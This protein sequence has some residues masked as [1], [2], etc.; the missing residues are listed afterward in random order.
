MKYKKTIGLLAALLVLAFLSVAIVPTIYHGHLTL[1]AVLWGLSSLAVLFGVTAVNYKYPTNVAPTAAQVY[2]L[3]LVTA[4][5]FMADA[6]TTVDITHSYGLSAQE[7]VDLFPIVV[8]TA[9]PQSGAT[10]FPG[11]TVQ[12]FT[13]K[14]TLGKPNVGA[15]T[16]GTFDVAIFRPHTNQGGPLVGAR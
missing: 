4:Q 2:G 13:N 15:G 3:G 8:I 5:V 7:L 9:P 1:K 6:D 12:K 10:L 14:I 11:F 16:G